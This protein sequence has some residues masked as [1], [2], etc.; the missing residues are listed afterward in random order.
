MPARVTARPGFML[1]ECVR[2]NDAPARVEDAPRG[3]GGHAFRMEVLEDNRLRGQPVQVRRFDPL[4]AISR[5]IVG[6]K[7]IGDNQDDIQI[8]ALLLRRLLPTRAA[9]LGPAG[10]CAGAGNRKIGGARES[11]GGL[12]EI[13]STGLLHGCKCSPFR[14][15]ATLPNPCTRCTIVHNRGGPEITTRT[16][17]RR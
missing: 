8:V 3:Y 6:A 16:Q 5:Q 14:L 1:K 15:L 13:P 10:S 2:R 7:R 11:C 17:F 4:A 9:H 12:Q